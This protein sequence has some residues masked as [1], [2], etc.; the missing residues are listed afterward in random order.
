MT[1]VDKRSGTLL[2]FTKYLCD[3][4]RLLRDFFQVSCLLS[5]CCKK[6]AEG[7]T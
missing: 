3:G 4:L 1:T 7:W 5:Y 2:V 6:W